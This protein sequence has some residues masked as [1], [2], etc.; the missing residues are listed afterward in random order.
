MKNEM[1]S[2]IG[3][4]FTEM[5][6]PFAVG[7]KTD[8][9]VSAEF[10]DAKWAAGKKKIAYEA[11]I[12]LDEKKKVIFM[13]EKTVNSGGGFSFGSS[14]EEFSQYKSTLMRKVKSVQYDAS[15]KVYE[16]ELNLGDISRAVKECAAKNGWKLKTVV[17]Q[18]KAIYK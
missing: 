15:G 16:Y 7:G 3:Q 18:K 5:H 4:K 12:L 13:Y 9:V 1:V 17:S 10:L 6:I 11:A 14:S 2:E 8:I